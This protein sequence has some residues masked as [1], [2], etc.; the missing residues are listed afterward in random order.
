MYSNIKAVL[1]DK[2]GTLLDY[3]RTWG[4]INR[5][6][7]AF[8]AGGD[9]ALGDHLLTVGGMDPA[10]GLTKGN[11]ALAAGNTLDIAET[12]MKHGA[13]VREDQLVR[14]L[15]DLF[16]QSARNAVVVDNIQENFRTL[17][18]L[19]LK[20]GIASSDNENAIRMFAGHFGL[21]AHLHFIAGYD[22]GYGHKPGPGMLEGFCRATDTAPENTAVVGD[23]LHDMEM[24][25]AGGAGLRVG[26]LT[27]T[28][29][30]QE[31]SQSSHVCLQHM[32]RFVDLL[33]A[34]LKEH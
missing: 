8:A 1:F 34:G 11:S 28:G 18:D 10:T 15:D 17:G 25:K 13:T 26:V 9:V 2:D 21:T 7:A 14:A 19:G 33:A 23:N 22:S 16:H 12:W 27:G 30:R 4:P 6:A 31:L 20:I 5:R 32:G 3:D 29:T 24:A